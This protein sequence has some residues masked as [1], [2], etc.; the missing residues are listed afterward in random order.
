MI[1][2]GH[3]FNVLGDVIFLMFREQLKCITDTRD[4]NKVR[5]A[6]IKD[7]SLPVDLLLDFLPKYSVFS[8]T[9]KKALYVCT[10][11]AY[12]LN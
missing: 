5:T 1:V 3:F 11:P 9:C 2:L 6:E 7:I 12:I 4:H 8:S 10:S